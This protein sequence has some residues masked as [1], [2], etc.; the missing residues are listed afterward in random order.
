M[1]NYITLPMN[2][3]SRERD[4]QAV[5]DRLAAYEIAKEATSV[6]ELALWKAKI[7]ESRS[8]RTRVDSGMSY[9]DQCRINS[10][11]DI[12]IRNILPFLLPKSINW[13]II[14]GRGR[15]VI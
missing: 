10:G 2:I 13:P 9:R 6:L 8:K 12:V 15:C 4:T 5:Y 1:E 14:S 3:A 11:A 7:D